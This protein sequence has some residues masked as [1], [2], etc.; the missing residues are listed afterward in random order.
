MKATGEIHDMDDADRLVDV[1]WS[2]AISAWFERDGTLLAEA[3]RDQSLPQPTYVRELF[4]DL[5]IGEAKRGKGGSPS[6][7]HP[8]VKRSIAAEVFKEW[9]AI[10]AKRKKDA[11][12]TTSSGIPKII[13]C[14]VI[15]GRRGVTEDSVRGVVDDVIKAGLTREK[16]RAWGR[17][18][19]KNT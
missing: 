18:T 8:W 5:A 11:K 9:D 14:A 6:E 2:A 15:A 7:Y 12:K 17:P 13:A 3:V 4:A 1:R 10:K 16:W 19:W